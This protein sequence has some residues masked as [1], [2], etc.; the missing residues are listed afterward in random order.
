[1]SGDL[2]ELD[3]S[4]DG[5]AD[6]D[7]YR[8]VSPW[9][10]LTLLFGVAS[11]LAFV[12]PL[13]ALIPLLAL[14]SAAVALRQ[15]RHYWPTYI[16]RWAALLG[17]WL[18]VL[19]L[20]AVPT[21]W[22]VWHVMV[23]DEAIRFGDQFMQ[24]VADGKPIEAHQ[25]SLPNNLRL[26]TDDSMLEIYRSDPARID[27]VRSFSADRPL[28]ILLALGERADVRL[29]EVESVVTNGTS[30]AVSLLYA[31]TF[32][33]QGT[34]RTFFERLILLRESRPNDSRSGWKVHQVAGDVLPRV[35][36]SSEEQPDRPNSTPRSE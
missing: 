10:V 3:A 16:G 6:V 30:A 12:H 25:L 4:A 24:L 2:T 18:A 28:R 17:L 15:I 14:F 1:M 19:V 9:A 26:P 11:A 23:E 20:V 13:L 7:S 32:D 27:G 31:I 22:L 8:A 34:R 21:R 36:S 5:L 33:D 35:M 29:Y